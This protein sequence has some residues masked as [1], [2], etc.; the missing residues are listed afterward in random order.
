M[1][2]T[3]SDGWVR[4]DDPTT[5]EVPNE[6]RAEQGY[7]EKRGMLP[8]SRGYDQGTHKSALSHFT[9]IITGMAT[10]LAYPKRHEQI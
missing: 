6:Q 1:D 9:P 2:A 3:Q 7:L 8:V 10:G 5:V 4:N